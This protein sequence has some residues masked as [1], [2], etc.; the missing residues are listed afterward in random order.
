MP[1]RLARHGMALAPLP[2]TRFRF[3]LR[4]AIHA[5][6]RGPLVEGCPCPACRDHTRAYLHYLV[7]ARELTGVRLLSLH[8]LAYLESLVRG[9]RR[10]I[11]AAAFSAYRTAVL[12]GT[13]PWDAK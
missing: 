10:A 5:D 9:A 2:D 8:N 13:A 4:P 7:R 11:A 1:T 6:D 12:A 3:D